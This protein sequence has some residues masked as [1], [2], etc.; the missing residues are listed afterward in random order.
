MTT[1]A[2]GSTHTDLRLTRA[3]A[4]TPRGKLH[5]AVAVAARRAREVNRAV[6]RNPDLTALREL[7]QRGVD[8]LSGDESRGARLI[9]RVCLGL[10]Q[11]LSALIPLVEIDAEKLCDELTG[12]LV[13]LEAAENQVARLKDEVAVLT[14]GLAFERYHNQ[15][16]RSSLAAEQVRTAA[17]IADIPP[18]RFDEPT[19]NRRLTLDEI[20]A[21]SVPAQL[22]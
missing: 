7:A 4:D 11:A 5:R 3:P 6:A 20:E 12:A 1:P 21:I 13:Q 10:D 14:Q 8:R 22:R 2:N 18:E 16:L 9:V 17:A 19:R 15:Q